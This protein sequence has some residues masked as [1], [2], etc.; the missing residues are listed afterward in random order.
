[1]LNSLSFSLTIFSFSHFPPLP[2]KLLTQ[3]VVGGMEEGGEGFGDKSSASIQCTAFDQSPSRLR[4]VVKSCALALMVGGA[5]VREL[6]LSIFGPVFV[7][8]A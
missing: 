1:M 4:T 7:S 3:E 6:A 8:D 5:G 2:R